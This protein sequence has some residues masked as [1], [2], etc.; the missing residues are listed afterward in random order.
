METRQLHL[1]DQLITYRLYSPPKAKSDR[2]LVLLH[3]AG[4]AGK[5]TWGMIASQLTHWGHILIP[6]LRGAGDTRYPDGQEHAFSMQTLVADL[7]RLVDH[8]AWPQFD[9]GG[10]SMGGLLSMLFKQ[11][12]AQRVRKQFLIES[13]LLEYA[14]L[15]RGRQLTHAYGAIVRQLRDGSAAAAMLDFMNVISPNRRSSPQAEATTLV[16]L[17]S[18]LQGFTHGLACVTEAVQSIDRE[19]LLAAQGDV[20]SL[21]GGLSQDPMHSFHQEMAENMPNWHY[22]MV[23]GTDHSLPYQKPRQVARI[24]NDEMERYLATHE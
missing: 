3:G 13:V 18:R 24:F 2:T 20:T 5:D 16:R 15:S 21:I 17:G 11:Q 10:Y 23:P 19:V 14:D 22:F 7:N 12:H 4:V 8:L 9:L 6:D 1:P